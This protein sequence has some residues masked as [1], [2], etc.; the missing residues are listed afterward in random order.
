[1]VRSCL[2]FILGSTLYPVVEILWR[3]R[4][5]SSMALAGGLCF[6]L[7]DIVCCR[8]MQKKSLAVKCAAGSLL[9]TFVEF[10]IG[11]CVNL[12]LKLNVWDY[13]ALP[14]NIL[15]QICLPFSAIWFVLTVPACALCSLC[16]RLAERIKAKPQAQSV[17]DSVSS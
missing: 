2:N 14:L 1:M 9:I 7:I 4:T 15:G 10:V 6:V 5:H 16:G 11:V 12:I 17:H 13:S 8:K 3:G